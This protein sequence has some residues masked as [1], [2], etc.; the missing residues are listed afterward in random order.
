MTSGNQSQTKLLTSEGAFSPVA[1]NIP[2][3]ATINGV[4][5]CIQA[6]SAIPG[7]TLQN[8]QLMNGAATIGAI[9]GPSAILT[10]A[11]TYYTFG[12]YGDMWGLTTATLDPALINSANFG[13]GLTANDICC[14]LCPVSTGLVHVDCVQITVYYN[15]SSGPP[16]RAG[17]AGGAFGCASVLP[18]QLLTF[19]AK[20]SGEQVDIEWITA[21]Q[22]NNALFTI[23]RSVDGENW[24]KVSTVPGAGNS[25]QTLTYNSTDKNPVSGTSYYRLVQTDYDGSSTYSSTVPVN[26]TLPEGQML[27]YPNPATSKLYCNLPAGS[28][29]IQAIRIIDVTG[30]VVLNTQVM[31]PENGHVELN[32]ANLQ[33]GIY[34][35]EANNGIGLVTRKSFIKR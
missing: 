34:M 6:S 1:D 20:P 9:R 30:R 7:V 12:G 31:V 14:P 13:L 29:G 17:G 18:V 33:S 11:L 22:T 23:E 26:F 35:V 24:G 3:G 21:S 5:V 10:G 25:D 32:T 15:G 2:A 19:T 8:I 27:L 16:T 28:A 4:E